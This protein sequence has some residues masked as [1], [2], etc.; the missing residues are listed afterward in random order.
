MERGWVKDQ[1]QRA[2][3]SQVVGHIVDAATG[4]R[5]QSRSKAK[6]ADDSASAHGLRSSVFVVAQ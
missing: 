4:T 6:R 1:P 3:I 2:A 5:T